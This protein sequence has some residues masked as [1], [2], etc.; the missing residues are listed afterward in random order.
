MTSLGWHASFVHYLRHLDPILKT[1]EQ[2]GLDITGLNQRNMI[3]AGLPDVDRI[4][5]AERIILLEHGAGQT[6]RKGA[7][8]Y[9]PS[10]DT[11]AVPS[12][13]LYLATNDR[14]AEQMR[15][16]LPNAT[17]AVV[18]S[19]AVEHLW[20]EEVA[21]NRIT[22]AV[23]WASPLQIPEAGTSWPW[24]MRILRRLHEL[25]GDRLLVHAH[26]RIAY[27]VERDLRR[28]RLD[29]EFE[30]EW[31]RAALDT[32]ILVCDNSSIIWEADAL[33]IGLVLMDPPNWN[34]NADHGLRWGWQ[35]EKI[36]RIRNTEAVKD[37][38][39]LAHR[40]DAKVFGKLTGA[41]ARAVEAIIDHVS[42]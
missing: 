34:P 40:P 4:P 33:G 27:R 22:F 16:R 26:P 18:G 30:P 8:V 24:S 39:R 10:G 20:W 14:I 35:A 2:R 1:A 21:S 25:Y 9:D 19:P 32:S 15:P 7:R 13:T 28:A 38:M 17:I 36:P 31:D 29:I 5:D 11:R 12:V 6:Y 41:T 42:D 3:V 23:H 37:A